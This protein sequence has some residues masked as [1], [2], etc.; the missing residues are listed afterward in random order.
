VREENDGFE[1]DENYIPPTNND[2]EQ[3]DVDDSEDSTLGYDPDIP[4]HEQVFP[5]KLR[6]IITEVSGKMNY[7]SDFMTMGVMAAAAG[8][9]GTSRKLQIKRGI[10]AFPSFWGVIIG[11]PGTNKTSPLNWCLAPLEEWDKRKFAEYMKERERYENILES[12]NAKKKGDTQEKP[13]EPR[14]EKIIIN[15]STPE[16]M[17]TL[18]SK[19]LRGLLAHNDELAAWV[20]SFAGYKKGSDKPLWIKIFNQGS[21]RVDRQHALPIWI[22]N[23]HIVVIGTMQ[24][25]ILRMLT[26]DNGAE[27]GFITRFCVAFPQNL[28]REYFSED[29]V[30]QETVK[31]YSR[32]MNNLLNLEL[33]FAEDGQPDPKTLEYTPEAKKVYKIWSD[34]NTDCWKASDKSHAKG[35]YAKLDILVHRF[36]LIIQGLLYA[37][38]EDDYETVGIEAM[39]F[40]IKFVE[41]L[42][43]NDHYM[44][45]SISPSDPEEALGGDKRILYDALEMEKI[46]TT[47]K[48]KEIA[49]QLRDAKKIKLGERSVDGFLT[50]KIYF[51]KLRKGEYKKLLDLS[52]KNNSENK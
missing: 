21:H 40:A 32:I 9:I 36:A 34:Y 30:S 47:F 11:E 18:H 49:T 37:C 3:G 27:D 13:E 4:L 46:Y 14:L 31:N 15:D 26:E 23:M 12:N 22:E 29:E 41:Y 51:E 10:Q 8:A 50:D 35:F 20:Y 39:K 6:D 43:I 28:D 48:I 5:E 45:E 17:I 24:P 52:K 33:D 7:H 16:A 19:N 25:G 2:T 38:G 44:R 42:R 1:A